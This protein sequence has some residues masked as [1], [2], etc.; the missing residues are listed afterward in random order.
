MVGIIPSLQC[1]LRVTLALIFGHTIALDIFVNDPALIGA[2]EVRLPGLIPS[3]FCIALASIAIWLILGV[4]TRSFAVLGAALYTVHEVILRG[5]LLP[6][7]QIVQSSLLVAILALPLIIFGG[8]RFSVN[9]D[10]Q[11]EPV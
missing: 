11:P 3:L 2:F 5:Q 10:L 9:A 7:P 4:G 1:A 8:G 6:D